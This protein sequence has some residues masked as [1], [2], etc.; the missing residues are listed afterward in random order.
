MM[1]EVPL[2]INWTFD[3]LKETEYCLIVWEHKPH[4]DEETSSDYNDT[5]RNVLCCTDSLRPGLRTSLM[6]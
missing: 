6:T 3:L 1:D 5:E 2:N 4:R